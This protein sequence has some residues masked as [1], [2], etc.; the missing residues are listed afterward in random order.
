MYSQEITRRHRTAF[1]LLVDRSASMQGRVRFGRTTATKAEA[2]AMIVNMLITELLDRCRRTDGLRNYYDVAVLGYGNNEVESLLG[3]DGFVSVEELSRRKPIMSC[4]A[5]EQELADGSA[6]IIERSRPCWIEA[7][8]EGTTPMYEA[9]LRVRD[10]VAG[11]C[12]QEQ[13]RDSFPPIVFNITDGEPTDC[14]DN[15]LRDIC[16]QIKRISTHDG[17]V[18]LLNIHICADWTL[19][20]VL[21]PMPDELTGAGRQARVLAECSSLLPASFDDAVCEL[22]GRG[23]VPPFYAMGYNAS[24]IELLSIINIGSR[25]II[26]ME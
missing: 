13:N 19:P 16:S 4:V 5:Y 9:L 25:S 15:E 7:H 8:A 2:V 14:D 12:E 17:E 10:M 6:A 24:V 23:A 1:V 11:W 26:N 18:L 21:F 20:S 22:K 3:V